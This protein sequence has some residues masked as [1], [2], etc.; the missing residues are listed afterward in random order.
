MKKTKFEKKVIHLTIKG[1]TREEDIHS[2]YGS[3]A[4]IYDYYDAEDI[5]I[6]YG[7]LRNYGLSENKFYENSKVIIR[8]GK[9][10]TKDRSV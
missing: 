5:G 8:Q 6:T 7:S 2:Y 10:F 9:L 3:V 4:C 1:E